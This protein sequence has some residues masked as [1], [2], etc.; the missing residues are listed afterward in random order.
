MKKKCIIVIILTLL[1][2]S[3][4]T[5]GMTYTVEDVYSTDEEYPAQSCW[6]NDYIKK[7]DNMYYYLYMDKLYV[8]DSDKKMG[9]IVCTATNCLHDDSKC[10]A[11]FGQGGDAESFSYL[12]LE[13]YNDR[14]YKIGRYFGEVTDFY[15]YS[16]SMDGS[17]R[18][19]MGYVY[20]KELDLDGGLTWSYDGE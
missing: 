18:I 15:I 7:V 3:G 5:N 9:A 8:W 17:E 1:F 11:Y 12:D 20:S 19:K 10:N 16:I 13:V 6:W 2:C 4:C 14:I